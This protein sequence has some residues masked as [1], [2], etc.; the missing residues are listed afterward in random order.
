MND[1]PAVT[2]AART[3]WHETQ[4]AQTIGKVGSAPDNPESNTKDTREIDSS[5]PESEE[6]RVVSDVPYTVVRAHDDLQMVLSAVEESA[7]VALDLETTGLNPRTDRVRLL[8]LAIDTVD[9]GTFSYLIDCFQIDPKPLLEALAD[10]ELVIHNAHFELG[11]LFR[12]GFAPRQRVHDTMLMAAVLGAGTREKVSLADCAHRY[13][14]RSLDKAEQRSDWSGALSE[15]QLNYA[16]MDVDVLKPLWTAIKARLI[17]AKL[18]RVAQIECRCLPDVVWMSDRG[19]AFARENWASLAQSAADECARVR[20]ELDATAP[21]P[22]GSMFEGWNWESP[23]Q[24][25]EAL[26]AVGCSV[27]NTSD[28]RLA[29]VD[30]P[31]GA[32]LRRYREVS[33]QATT[34]GHDWLKHVASDG[35]V[36]PHWRQFGAW[37]GRMSCS[38]PNMQQMPRGEYRQCVAAPPGRVLVKADYS[39]IELRL[40]AKIANET[41]MIEAY[42]RGDDLHTLTAKQLLGTDDVS[43]SDRQL[44]KA[45]NFG[46]LYGMGARGLRG[47]A[48]TAYGVE[49][50][51]EQAADYRSK[52]FQSYP[53]LA[54]WHRKVGRLGNNPSETRTIIGRRLIAVKGFCEK[55][56][57][58]VQGSGADGLKTALALLWERRDR[59]PGSFPVMAIHDEIVVEA[60]ADRATETEAWLKSAMIDAM[61]PLADPVPVQVECSNGGTWAED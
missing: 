48:R 58:P 49:L 22:P 10:K 31:L 43:K 53:G 12:M 34:Y 37:S 24:V 54:A 38:E 30:H 8:S 6:H 44:A 61:A 47:Y 50:T 18:N 55:L 39:Q 14:G 13:L 4:G 11:F 28:W 60:S 17:E 21:A 46:L 32:L 36:Y 42:R 9:G 7:T 41:V 57:T 3:A 40:A 23:K 29:Q 19:V 5:G 56:N 1:A 51:E 35:R 25:Q 2:E 26:T 45:L 59:A 20:A 27:E 52:F 16:A 33:K 15:S